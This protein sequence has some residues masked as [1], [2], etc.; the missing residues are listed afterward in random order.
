MAEIILT[1]QQ[2][3]QSTSMANRADSDQTTGI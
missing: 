2:V 1:F 3:F